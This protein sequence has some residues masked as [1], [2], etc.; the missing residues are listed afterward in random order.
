MISRYGAFIHDI[1]L[2]AKKRDDLAGEAG[3]SRMRT[4][5]DAAY[6]FPNSGSI[7][8]SNFKIIK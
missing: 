2:I 1:F 5:M 6:G 3:E 8:L 4:I 7:C